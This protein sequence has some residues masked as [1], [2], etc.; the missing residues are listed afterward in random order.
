MLLGL[1]KEKTML[2]K[3]LAFL[4]NTLSDNGIASY[5][6]VSGAAVIFSTI[7]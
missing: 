4:R 7:V 5:S 2:S 3:L 1:M 6:R